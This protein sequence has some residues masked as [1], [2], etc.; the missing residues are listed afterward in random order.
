MLAVEWR[1]W[2]NISQTDQNTSSLL[3]SFYKARRCRERCRKITND[4]ASH[5]TMYATT[6]SF[7]FPSFIGYFIYL[8][9]KC[10]PLFWFPLLKAPI[11][12]PLH[13]LLWR[14][15]PT[16]PP[17]L[18]SPLWHYPT[19]GHWSFRGPRVPPPIDSWKGHPLLHML[20]EPWVVPCILFGW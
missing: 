12:S 9:L 17:T 8:H 3:N 13:L 18:A 19:L 5:S 1:M 11:S 10:Y 20:L 6:Q 2:R 7:Y 15:S 14:H 4:F 16:H